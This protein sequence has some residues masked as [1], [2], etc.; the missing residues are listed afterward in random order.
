[1]RLAKDL[2][3]THLTVSDLD[4]S[5]AFYRDVIGLELA[6]VTPLQQAAF[7]WIGSAGYA[8]LGLWK[9]GDGPQRMTLHLAFRATV[10]DVVAA[11][12]MLQAAGIVP[13]DF[14]GQQTAEPVVI[15]WMP[16][17]S[18]FF[19]DPDGHLLEYIAMLPEAPRP[20]LGVVPWNEWRLS[21][22]AVRQHE[23]P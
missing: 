17:A 11:P 13:L 19:R 22:R 8:M 9:S 16:A 2:F 18:V 20:D 4:R 15:G 21:N 23:V 14:D 3:E 1:M 10:D 5:I 6:Y 12:R 7:F